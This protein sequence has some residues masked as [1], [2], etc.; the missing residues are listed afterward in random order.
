MP[1]ALQKSGNGYF[2]VNQNTGKKYSKKALTKTV[3]NRQMAAL[4]MHSVGEGLPNPSNDQIAGLTMYNPASDEEGAGFVDMLKS[5]YNKVAKT[6]SSFTNAITGRVDA[7]IH[8]RNDYPPDE[9][10]LIAKHADCKIVKIC[11]Y[12]EKLAGYI[13]KLADVISLGDFS[14][15]KEK[16]GIDELYHLFMVATVMYNGNEVPI[17][18]EKN[19]VI[20]LK[21]NPTIKPE[22]PNMPLILTPAFNY[23]FK[24]LLDNGRAFMGADWFPYNS[25]LNNCQRFILSIITANPPLLKDNPEAAKFIQQETQGL[26]RDLSPHTRNFFKGVTD[27]AAKFNILAKGKGFDGSNPAHQYNPMHTGIF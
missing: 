19:E 3:A 24:E 18:I 1:Y 5:A 14:R 20:H 27:L 17:L 23:T 25:L 7:L 9:R 22:L 26:N 11:L 16:H 15:V 21:E 8:G 13:S 10:E 4:R 2:V 6:T 12:R